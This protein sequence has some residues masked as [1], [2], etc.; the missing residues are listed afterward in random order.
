MRVVRGLVVVMLAGV[1]VAGPLDH[2]DAVASARQNSTDAGLRQQSKNGTPGERSALALA[3]RDGRPVEVEAMRTETRQ[4]FAKPD[5]TYLLEQ[6]ARPVRVRQAGGWVAAD[7]A[8]RLQPDGT[9]A[10]VATAVGLGSP[11]AVGTARRSP[12]CPAAARHWSSAGRA[13]AEADAER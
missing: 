5:G 3:R 12:R 9:L 13:T 2:L 6:Y 10:P 11:A 8:L 7:A 1:V 4:V